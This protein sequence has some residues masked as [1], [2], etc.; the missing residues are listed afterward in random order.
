MSVHNFVPHASVVPFFP[1]ERHVSAYADF[2]ERGRKDVNIWYFD[3]I[4]YGPRCKILGDAAF[5]H[6]VLLEGDPSIMRYILEYPTVRTTINDEIVETTLD[7][8]AYTR[9]GREIW[10][11]FKR[12]DDSGPSRRGR[13]QQ[14]LSAQAQAASIAGID[15]EVRTDRS[16][17]GKEIRFNN[18]LHL[19]AAINRCRQYSLAAEVFALQ[20][21]FSI[22]EV[23]YMDQLLSL[24]GIDHALML[25]AIATQLHAG[26]LTCDLDT[27]LYSHA[28]LIRLVR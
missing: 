24:P 17:A 6:I 28:S 27:E 9:D 20:Q 2:K 23:A 4:K 8:T 25:G 15:Y 12:E 7:A 10:L 3:T 14:Q 26:V 1:H 5:I 16:L 19:C 11:E 18:W 21:L 13:A 22:Q